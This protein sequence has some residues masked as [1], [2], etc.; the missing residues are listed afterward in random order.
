MDAQAVT[1]LHVPILAVCLSLSTISIAIGV[2]AWFFSRAEKVRAFEN[3]IAAHVL[4]LKGRVEAAESKALD[5]FTALEGIAEEAQGLFQ[6]VAKERRRITQ[7]NVRAEGG[8]NG[9]TGP[10][11]GQTRAEQIAAVRDSFGGM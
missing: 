7:E 2:C 10:Q 1:A 5:Q 9:P 8:A 6:R 4:N 3:Q 11:I